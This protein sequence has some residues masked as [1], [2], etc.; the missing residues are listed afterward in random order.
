MELVPGKTPSMK[1]V[2]AI[3]PEESIDGGKH[4]GLIKKSQKSRKH[5]KLIVRDWGIQ[6][7]MVNPEFML[8]V[9]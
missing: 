8:L 6:T 5:Q 4:M 7:I 3:N 9:S 2:D 1:A